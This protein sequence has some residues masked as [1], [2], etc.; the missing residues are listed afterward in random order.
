MI[1]DVGTYGERC[2]AGGGK[3]IGRRTNHGGS[4]YQLVASQTEQGR[5]Y[6]GSHGHF[7]KD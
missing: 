7:D 1:V 2:H 3:R 6:G 4:A 5:R